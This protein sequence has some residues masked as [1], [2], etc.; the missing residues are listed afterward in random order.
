M[1]Q[2]R[3]QA[4]QAL[5][6]SRE[7]E[8]PSGIA[9]AL[10]G[11]AYFEQ[12]ESLPQRRRLALAEE[13]LTWARQSGDDFLV[14]EALAERALALPLEQGISEVERAAAALRK[15]GDPQEL[16]ALYDMAAHGAIKAGK[17]ECALPWLDHALPLARDPEHH[18]LDLIFVVG[19]VGLQALFTDDLDRAQAGF[20]EQLR[21]CSEHSVG[22]LAA[23]GLLGLAAIAA[24]RA[25]EER[26]AR[27]LGAAT[28]T[29]PMGDPEVVRQLEE[30]FLAPA[31]SGYGEAAL[32]RGASGGRPA[33]LR[34][35]DRSRAQP[36]CE[37]ELRLK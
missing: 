1:A 14:A 32:G 33:E 4:T 7:A 28:A 3:A 18:H 15:L 17:A 8:D 35:G 6:L 30:Q 24:C 5:A 23:Q 19:T 21:L 16:L 20:E 37:G 25:Q 12:R 13:A 34:T 9:W 31:R 29:G 22:P 2:A 11:L 26:A 10:I 27:L 36:R